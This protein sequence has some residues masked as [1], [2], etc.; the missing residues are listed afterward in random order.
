MKLQQDG[1]RLA[2]NEWRKIY[3]TSGTSGVSRE[4]Y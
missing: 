1:V 2:E 4:A 3:V